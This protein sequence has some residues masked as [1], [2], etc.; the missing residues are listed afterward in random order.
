MRIILTGAAGR[1]GA[2]MID[3]LSESHEL[4]LLDRHTIPEKDSICVDLARPGVISGWRR[5]LSSARARWANVFE[6]ADA[7][8]HLG[9]VSTGVS[10]PQLVNSNISAT[11]NLLRAA[12]YH[13]VPRFVFASSHWVIKIQ[14]SEMA[15]HCYASDGPKIRSDQEPRPAT[16]YGA[17]KALGEILGRMFVD[18]GRIRSFGAVRIGSYSDVPPIAAEQRLVWIRTAD[19]RSLLRSA[20]EG[21]LEGY[22][23]VYGISAQ[24]ISPFGLS[25]TRALL[26][27]SPR[28][29]L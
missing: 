15:P 22:H 14:E 18:N 17:S 29:T 7:V 12:A 6:S 21:L 11:W 2:E 13:Q 28:Q 1:I 20:L 16:P 19:L 25:S 4:V 27:W 24:S 26:S 23:I 9:A 3:E 8:L 5:R 10:W